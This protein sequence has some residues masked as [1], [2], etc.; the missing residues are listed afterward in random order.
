[1]IYKVPSG[2]NKKGEVMIRIVSVNNNV[3]YGF[4]SGTVYVSYGSEA[5]LPS[6]NLTY[7]R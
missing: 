3:F 4:L 2:N 5:T 7:E 6:L 1:M